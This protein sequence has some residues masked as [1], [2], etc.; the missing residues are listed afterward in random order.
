MRLSR[1]DPLIR[2]AVANGLID[3]A[4]LDVEPLRSKYGATP[5]VVDGI[6]FHSTREAKR[7]AELK[8]LEAAGK[9][10]DLR[11]QVPYEL[12]TVEVY[13]ADFVY[14]ENGFEVVEDVKGFMTRGYKRKRRLMKAQ[15][16]II[17]RET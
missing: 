1:S 16:G 9:I 5:K 14:T 8:A 7:Y 2:Q 10:S 17:I 12:I 13:R 15:Y 6:R 11:L 3:P 4:A